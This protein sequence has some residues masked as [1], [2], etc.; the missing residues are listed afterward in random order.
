MK[1]CFYN[2]NNNLRILNM[3]FYKILV[4]TE[5]IT[6]LLLNVTACPT[7]SIF[8]RTSPV[9]NLQILIEIRNYIIK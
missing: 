1:H 8:T 5:Q 4:C 2:E 9:N 7:T 3:V 6:H